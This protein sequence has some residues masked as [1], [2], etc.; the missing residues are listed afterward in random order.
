MEMRKT[1]EFPCGLMIHQRIKISAFFF[2]SVT[3]NDH[4]DDIICPMH[5][6]KCKKMVK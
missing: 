4:I 5:G 1:V 3:Y 6:E 2:P